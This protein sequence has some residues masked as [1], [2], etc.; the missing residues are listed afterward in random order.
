MWD[1]LRNALTMIVILLAVTVNVSS[2]QAQPA[3]RFA[4]VVGNGGYLT[5]EPLRNPVRDAADMADALKNLGFRVTIGID[6]AK[7]EFRKLLDE[8]VRDSSGATEILFFYAGH[9][10]QLGNVNRLV[11]VDAKLLSRDLID[12]ETVSLNDVMNAIRAKERRSVILLDACRNN[13]LP[14]ALRRPGD[15]EGLA[16]IETGQELFV[17]FAT[18]PG[19]VAFDG[20]GRNSPFTKALLT[21]MTRKGISISDMMVDLRKDVFISTQGTQVPWDQSSLRSQ[22][23]FAP[24]ASL[25]E[26]RIEQPPA[27]GAETAQKIVDAGADKKTAEKPKQENKPLKVTRSSKDRPNAMDYS[28]RI[29]GRGAMRSGTRRQETEFGTLVCNNP[30]KRR[31]DRRCH[32]E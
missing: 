8:F 27:A 7:W 22:F 30:S 21:H 4:L 26:S 28:R 31:G 13:P 5:V 16:K 25:I 12:V 32:W 11:P 17:A 15:G 3:E 24:T 29:W 6:L 1:Q 14:E 19:N 2:S 23:Y 20:G 10:F 18:Q 9:G